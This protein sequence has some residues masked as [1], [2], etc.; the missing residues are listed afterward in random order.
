MDKELRDTVRH[1]LIASCTY[2]PPT[3]VRIV[4]TRASEL[5][6]LERNVVALKV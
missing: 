2:T 3:V 6:V 1:A 5:K 4:I